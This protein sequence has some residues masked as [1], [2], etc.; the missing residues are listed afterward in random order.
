MDSL[1]TNQP[2]VIDNGSGVL[3]AGIAGDSEPKLSIPALY[4]ADDDVILNA[5]LTNQPTLPI[6][7]G[8]GGIV[9]LGDRNTHE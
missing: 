5:T 3:K 2:V 6:M 4:V 9:A 1:I 7:C 8:C